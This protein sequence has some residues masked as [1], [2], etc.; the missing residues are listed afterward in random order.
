MF[1]PPGCFMLRAV[2]CFGLFHACN[3]WLLAFA[4]ELGF[5]FLK[6]RVW[7]GKCIKMQGW[8]FDRVHRIGPLLNCNGLNC[9]GF[10]METRR[11]IRQIIATKCSNGFDTSKKGGCLGTHSTETL[12]RHFAPFASLRATSLGNFRKS[13]KSS[14]PFSHTPPLGNGG[15]G[16]A[17]A[18]GRRP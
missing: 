17:S 5:S 9:T 2:S 1:R 8:A 4:I 10:Q 16:T 6:C 18:H 3:P 15:L 14:V 12:F 11:A 7:R 13:R